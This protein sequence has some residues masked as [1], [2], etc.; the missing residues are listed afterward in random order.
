M[1]DIGVGVYG[2]EFPKIMCMAFGFRAQSMCKYI[3]MCIYIYICIHT[4]IYI[5][6]YICV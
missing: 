3:H 1:G 4:C 6:I 5:Y 2:L